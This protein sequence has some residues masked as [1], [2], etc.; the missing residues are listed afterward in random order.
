MLYRPEKERF[1]LLIMS[2][3]FKTYLKFVQIRDTGKTKIFEVQ[4]FKYGN[5][6]AEVKYYGAWRKYTLFPE[7]NTL[8]DCKCLQEISDFMKIL[9]EERR[10]GKKA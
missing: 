4:S 10:H 9:M 6:L 3:I 5:K 1:Y 7:P 8:F 2:S